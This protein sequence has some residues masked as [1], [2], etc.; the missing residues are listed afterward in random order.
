[1]DR[2]RILGLTTLETRCLPA[3]LIEVIEILKEFENMDLDRSFQAI[4]DGVRRGT[5][6]NEVLSMN[7]H[8]GY[9]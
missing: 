5:V 9:N 2:L 4:G 6:L 3:D 1:M 7:F 8:G